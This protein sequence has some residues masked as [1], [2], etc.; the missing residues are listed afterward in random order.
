MPSWLRG[1]A[2]H[3]PVS[4]TADAVRGLMD[5]TPHGISTWMSLAWAAG[6]ILVLAPLAV[7]QYRKVA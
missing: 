6:A 5:G 7:N 1:F 3:Q 4:Q 2:T